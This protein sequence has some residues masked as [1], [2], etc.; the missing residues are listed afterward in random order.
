MKVDTALMVP[1]P[2][3]P[4]RARKI[5]GAGYDGAFT[6]EIDNDPL[7]PLLLA[8][9]HTRNLEL[10]TAITVAFARSPMTLA[11]TAHDIQRFSNGRLLLGLGSQIKPHITR[12][13]S[14]EWSHP[15]DRMR[16]YVLALRAIWAAWNDGVK[17]DF[18]GRFYTHTLMTPMFTP[19]PSPHGPPRVLLAAV[20]PRMTEVAGE[21]ADGVILHGFT[22]E[23]YVREVSLP[24]I[25]RGLERSGRHRQEFSVV[26]PTF[27]V[28]GS[29]DAQKDAAMAMVRS[30]IG[31]YGSTPAYRPVLEVEGWGDLQTDLHRATK[32][33]RW[34]DLPDI[35]PDSVVDTFAIVCD[36]EELPDRLGRRFGDVVDRVPISLPFAESEPDRAAAIVQAVRSLEPRRPET[37]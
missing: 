30:Q 14:M 31:F 27:V 33:N 36:P 35:V 28:T 13:F 17:L 23:K 8:A 32:E 3:V 5:E 22:T 1:L 6:A 34:A 12:R 15:A 7:L 11:Q 26:C 25:E 21:V 4:E 37:R 10:V 29:D 16:E 9:E 2:D 19:E 20:G 24:A 18:D